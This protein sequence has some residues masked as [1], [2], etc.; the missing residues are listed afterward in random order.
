MREIEVFV[1]LLLVFLSPLQLLGIAAK[2]L[3]VFSDILMYASALIFV[4]GQA[5]AMTWLKYLKE[6]VVFALLLYI[7]VQAW[8]FILCLVLCSR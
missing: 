2:N 1:M 6:T 3:N 5:G 7:D 4:R 8:P